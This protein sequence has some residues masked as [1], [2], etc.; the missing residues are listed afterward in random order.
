MTLRSRAT[1]IMDQEAIPK[2]RALCDGLWELRK[3]CL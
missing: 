1:L 3:G 2:I